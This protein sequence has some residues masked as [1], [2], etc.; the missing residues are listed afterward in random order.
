MR[1]ENNNAYLETNGF[2]SANSAHETTDMVTA[3][4]NL[5][6]A[7][8]ADR[9]IVMEIIATNRKLVEANTTIATQVKAL[10]ATNALLVATQEPTATKKEYNATTK[11][12]QLPIASSGY[13]WSHG[14]KLRQGH[15]SKTCGVKQQG[16]QEEATRTNTL[17]GKMWNKPND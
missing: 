8:T 9:N 6:L 4:D 10:V 11:R 1:Y 2:N 3:L 15:T 17:G 7:A 12:E 5:A 16:N 13:C 14:Y